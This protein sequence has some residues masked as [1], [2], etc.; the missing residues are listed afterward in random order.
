MVGKYRSVRRVVM[1]NKDTRVEYKESK[2]QKSHVCWSLSQIAT[3]LPIA[4][5]SSPTFGNTTVVC[6]AFMLAQRILFRQVKSI[7]S[8]N[9]RIAKFYN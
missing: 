5:T 1:M 7:V 2:D 6:S 3:L 8:K 9:G 4:P